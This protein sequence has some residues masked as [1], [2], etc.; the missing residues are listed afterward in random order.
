M[1]KNEG[2]T[3]IEMLVV[4]AIIGILSAI[5]I[6]SLLSLWNPLKSAANMVSGKINQMHMMARANAD[7]MYCISSKHPNISSYPNGI[8]NKFTGSSYLL[9]L[10]SYDPAL[11]RSEPSLDF[12]LPD[13]ISLSKF[14][15]LG[16]GNI[17]LSMCNNRDGQGFERYLISSSHFGYGFNGNYFGFGIN[18]NWIIIS[19]KEGNT[20]I[21]AGIAGDAGGQSNI[22]Y[23]RS[24]GTSPET[25]QQLPNY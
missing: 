2:Y 6:P 1:K 10:V 22:V 13:G 11:S 8:V 24:L 7:R 9:P 5:G 3:L 21:D 4:I 20:S 14:Q 15:I 12:E 19:K 16:N 18:S 25:Y 17:Y 23:R